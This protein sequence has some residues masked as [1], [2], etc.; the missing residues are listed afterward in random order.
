LKKGAC[1]LLAVDTASLKPTAENGAQAA[2]LLWLMTARA[3][4]AIATSGQ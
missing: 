1:A 2:T 4:G 3:L